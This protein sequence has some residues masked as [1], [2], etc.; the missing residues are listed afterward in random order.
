MCATPR[1]ARRSPAGSRLFAALL[2]A[3]FGC[4]LACAAP[5]TAA[6][7]RPWVPPSA[8]TLLASATEA[9]ALFQANTGDSVTGRN[10][11]AYERVARM[12]EF[13]L[14]SMGRAGMN[15]AFV[16][17]DVL[18]SLGLDVDVDLD[19]DLP[20][21]ALMMVRNPFRTSAASVAYLYWYRQ[22]DLRLQGLMVAGGH[23]PKS[24][25][26]WTGAPTAPYSWGI[27]DRS[28]SE[29][30]TLGLT[31]LRLTQDGNAW[32]LV[33]FPTDSTGLGFEGTAEW[34]DV[35]RDGVPEVVAWVRGE[36]DPAFAA[37]NGCPGTIVQRTFVERKAGFQI[38]ESRPVP[39]AF[40]TF[41]HFLRLLQDAQT[42]AAERLVARPELVGRAVGFGWNRGGEGIWRFE[43]AEPGE[44]WPRWMT[45]GLEAADGKKTAY[46]VRFGFADGRW[47]IEDLVPAPI[48]PAPAGS[49]R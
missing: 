26:W 18:D 4:V 20:F 40:A 38:E 42:N 17:E 10:Y 5:A 49:S 23:E 3:A 19:P 43:L 48:A 27:L 15:Q 46:T 11:R 34:A 29:P 30:P 41:A 33:Q 7:V 14:R 2:A 44:R 35:N 22:D 21:F 16:V 28:Q 37:C 45:F 1:S 47:I 13:I 25:V 8:D 36:T 32:R 12:G 24:K 31:L 39:T 6:P 9:R